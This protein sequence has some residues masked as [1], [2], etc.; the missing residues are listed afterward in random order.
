[1]K[2]RIRRVVSIARSGHVC[3]QTEPVPPLAPGQLLV[4][5]RASL[6]SAGTELG[7]WT[8]QA[9]PDTP[10]PP[11]RSFGYQNAGEVVEVGDG[12]S[13]F[14]VGQRVA[15]MGA[16][17]ALHSDW[18]CVPQRMAVPLP[19]AVSDEEGAFAALAP[20]AMHA[21]RRG[22]VK[23]GEDTAIFGLGL[24]GQLTAQVCQIA[25]AR[26]L[27]FDHHPLR[28][29]R[30][31]KCGVEL[32][33]PESGDSA[34]D[35]AMQ[36]TG[37]R[38]LDSAFICFGGDATAVMKDAV[39]MMQEA[40]DTHRYG[41][42]VLVGGATVTHTFG[43]A[44]GNLDL[45]SAAR[46]GPGYHDEA[47][48]HGADYPEVFVRWTTQAHLRLFVRWI[49]EGKLRVKDLITDRVPVEDAERACYAMMDA[50]QEHLGVLF[51]Y[52]AD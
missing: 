46:T 24:V 34:V 5:V 45:R 1:M 31:R 44:L 26:T 22:E 51:E 33:G 14:E 43:A 10:L 39:R 17:Y 11:Y 25:G 27:A 21:V 12:C 36:M 30:A 47:Y 52:G 28:V 16:G 7:A 18:V 32:A 20:T 23:F 42:I 9:R 15:C 50:P 6:I 48:E 13:G 37:R 3:V 8:G 38:G 4:R 35:R 19:D 2:E 40:P 29:E 41:P 49:T